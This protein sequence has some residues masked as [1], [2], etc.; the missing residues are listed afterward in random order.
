MTDAAD[1]AGLILRVRSGDQEA[2]A[3]LVRVYE[4]YV[5]RAVRIQLRDPRMRSIVDTV[6]ICQSVMASFFARLN[7]GQYDLSQPRQLSALLITMARSK[8]ATRARRADVVRRDRQG[9]EAVTRA[10]GGVIDPA[11][12]PSRVIAGRDLLEQFRI[13]L[14]VDERSLSDLRADGR[15]WAEIASELGGTPDALR[16]KLARALDRVGCELGLDD[17][18]DR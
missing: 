18:T 17:P 1:I 14:K 12:D 15:S 16:K 10:M 4:P 3:E 8:V 2:A 5:R 7:F 6:D 9:Q 13:R 11:P